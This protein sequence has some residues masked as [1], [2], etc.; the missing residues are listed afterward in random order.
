[1]SEDVQNEKVYKSI[2]SLNPN[3]G[4]RDMLINT[5]PIKFK[6]NANVRMIK[7]I[8]EVELFPFYIPKI[9]GIS[10]SDNIYITIN[11]LNYDDENSFHFVCRVKEKEDYLFIKPCNTFNIQDDIHRF[12]SNMIS[13]SFK[14]YDFTDLPIEYTF[15]FT[16]IQNDLSDSIFNYRNE[17]KI[18]LDLNVSYTK[19]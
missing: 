7:Y 14:L 1:M 18:H 3:V 16:D 8:T 10:N 6:T 15:P 11:E 2:F 19:Y 5:N 9:T 12:R 4:N 17:K 13:L